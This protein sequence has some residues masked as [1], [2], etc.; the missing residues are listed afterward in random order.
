MK[1][2]CKNTV[3]EY[4]M[5]IACIIHPFNIDISTKNSMFAD[6]LI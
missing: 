1:N 4:K 5:Q 3:L 6:K 2:D